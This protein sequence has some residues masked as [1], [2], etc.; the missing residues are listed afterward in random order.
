[1]D[2]SNSNF[3]L[4]VGKIYFR[5]LIVWKTLF[6]IMIK[7]IYNHK[8]YFTRIVK[9]IECF[10]TVKNKWEFPTGHDGVGFIGFI[11]YYSIHSQ[12]LNEGFF[13]K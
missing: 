2:S 8:V 6:L 1:M 7:Y 5:Y 11:L 4:D 10:L 3:G 13:S 9:A 12:S